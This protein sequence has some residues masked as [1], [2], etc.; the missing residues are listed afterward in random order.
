M[1]VFGGCL[2]GKNRVIVAANSHAQA[3]RAW[4][5]HY[6]RLSSYYAR[7]HSNETGNDT[8]IATAMAKPGM[9]FW[10]P[11]HGGIYRQQRG[12]DAIDSTKTE[13]DNAR[14]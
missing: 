13:K 9:V 10:K 1:K 12:K 6:A 7:L 3:I 8:E 5:R 14:E 4:Q 2:D 11:L